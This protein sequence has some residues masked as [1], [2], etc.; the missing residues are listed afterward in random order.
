MLVYCIKNKI[1]SK[2]YIGLTTRDLTSR[3]KQHIQES[4]KMGSWEWN[5]PFGNAIKKYGKDNFDVFVLHLCDSLDEL[6]TKE[7]EY[8]ENR[9]SLVKHGGY[10][11]TK[12]GDGRLGFK[13]SEETKK[14]IGLGNL[15][16]VMSPE[17]KIRCSIAKKGKYIGGNHPRAIKV[18]IND[19]EIFDCLKD[20]VKKYKITHRKIKNQFNKGLTTFEIDGIKIQK[21]I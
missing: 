5:T 6:K 12:G 11:L 20:F 19:N 13:L 21:V 4:N 15:G 1:N 7:I 3:W 10:N 17:A 9:K 16:K 8:I 2:E 18:L 14:K